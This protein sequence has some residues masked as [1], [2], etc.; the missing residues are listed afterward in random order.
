[1]KKMHIETSMQANEFIKES[2]ANHKACD[3]LLKI[4]PLET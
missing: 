2:F 4:V 1:M 3:D